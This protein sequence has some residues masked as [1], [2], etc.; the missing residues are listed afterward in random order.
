[1]A[2]SRLSRKLK[3]K[4]FSPR[5]VAEVGVYLPET[6]KIYEFILAGTRTTLVE[7]SPDAIAKIRTHFAGRSNV[8][9]HPVAVY[10]KGGV[11][12][13]IRRGASTFA[14]AIAGSPA[15]VND[16]YA[17]Q[18]ADR[19]TVEAV[20]FDQIDDGTIDLLCIDVEGGE[21]F[22]I[23]HMT[24]RPAII[25]LETHGVVY[26]NPFMCEIN[27]WMRTNRYQLWYKDASDSV[28]VKAG[29]FAITPMDNVKLLIASAHYSFKRA[30]KIAKR[31]LR[32]ASR[33][34]GMSGQL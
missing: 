14:A 12:E 2:S 17:L 9:L 32:R 11:L 28:Y 4:R 8:T 5:H 30:R 20:T 21:W 7:P 1:M 27:D 25:S 18:D 15:V 13:L 19:F 23:R 33:A 16:R 6:S 31:G 26:L 10:D 22:V 34:L 3:Q 29:A 24:S